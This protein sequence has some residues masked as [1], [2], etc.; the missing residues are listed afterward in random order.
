MKKE[1][2][3]FLT[4]AAGQW[5]HECV[6]VHAWRPRST[7]VRLYIIRRELKGKRK[8]RRKRNRKVV[9][10]VQDLVVVVDHLEVQILELKE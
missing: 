10:V 2:N 7:A 3:K 5:L 6:T 1:N 8:E 9:P 4:P